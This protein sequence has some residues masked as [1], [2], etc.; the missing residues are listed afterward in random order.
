LRNETSA[1]HGI[2]IA[3]FESPAVV[4]GFDDVAMVGQTVEQ[5]SGHFGVS[6]HAR[7]FSECE[8]GGDD[9]GSAL[10]E[11]ADEM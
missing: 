5:C 4:S 2:F 10:V 6:E 8:I 7:P 11:P 1:G 3:A 9:D